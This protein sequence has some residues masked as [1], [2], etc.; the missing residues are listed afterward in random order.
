MKYADY[1]DF[2][3]IFHLVMGEVQKKPENLTYVSFA[4][5][6]FFFAQA[7]TENFEKCTNM[8]KKK[9]PRGGWWAIT[10]LCDQDTTPYGSKP[11][12]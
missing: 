6:L 1:G 7:N 2:L 11:L 9:S 10:T 8:Q 5:C 3:S 12:P 4:F